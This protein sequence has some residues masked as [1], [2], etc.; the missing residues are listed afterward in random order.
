MEIKGVHPSVLVGGVFCGAYIGSKF[1]KYRKSFKE[2]LFNSTLGGIFG[3][4]MIQFHPISTISLMIALPL[5][6]IKYV[7]DSDSDK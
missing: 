5:T 4:V 3:Y 7:S 1:P 2:R 6:Y